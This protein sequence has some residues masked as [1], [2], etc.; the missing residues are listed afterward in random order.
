M[1]RVIS[2]AV[3][4]LASSIAFAQAQ[5]MTLQEAV[6]QA[7]K[8]SPM[9]RAA[10]AEFDRA[11]AAERGARAMTGPQVSANGFASLGN[12]ESI[13]TSPPG[14]EPGSLMAMPA[15]SYA[16]GNI[17]VMVPVLAT[18]VQAMASSSRWQA[19]AAAGEFREAEAELAFAVK[20]A[21]FT[22]RSAHE[23]VVA[24]AAT[25]T[26][27]QELLR[28]TKARFESGKVVEAAVQRV[29]ADVWRAER[30]LSTARN[31][32]AKALLDLIE[33]IGGN[34]GDRLALADGKADVEA[35]GDP[36]DTLVAQA[37]AHRGLILATQARTKAAEAD[38]RAARA[39]GMPRLYAVGMADG[40]SQREMG[41]LS[42]GLAL[43]FPLFD[44][45]RV[46]SGIDQSKASKTRADADL[47]A[48]KLLIEKEVRQAVLDHQTAVS[49]L[50]SSEAE[51]Q[52]AE[53]SYSVVAA[54]VEAGKAILLEQLD[55]LNLVS[56]SKAG[57]NKARLDLALS[58]ARV[59][60]ATGGGK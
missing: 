7:R 30:D 13:F 20:R 33:V 15:D 23:D 5:Q 26:A 3:V 11:F 50:A 9:L 60:R 44:G 28:V 27:L 53:S 56:T 6:D 37:L 39:L 32:E 1:T 4:A 40:A 16:V 14:T 58:S 45:G 12:M 25:L 36:V 51:V 2:L 41:G 24:S 22:A 29:Q 48:A 21:Y 10:R 18:E 57:L 55:A 54:R 46:R 35:P 19:Q 8:S 52:A 43:S 49:N 47:D 59:W 42:V 31:S 17:M 34:L 38:V